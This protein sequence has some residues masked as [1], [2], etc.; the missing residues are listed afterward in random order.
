VTNDSRGRFDVVLLPLLALS[1]ASNVAVVGTFVANQKAQ[2]RPDVPIGTTLKPIAGTIDGGHATTVSYGGDKP[3]VLYIFSST[4]SWCERN[5][6]SISSLSEKAGSRYRF[7][8]IS[9]PSSGKGHSASFNF[10]VV[11][12]GGGVPFRATPQT[13]VVDA[14]GRVVKS[15][16]GAYTGNTKTE[17]EQFFSLKL[18][19]LE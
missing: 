10:P 5:L 18:P 14:G 3:V 12:T 6:A 11:L 16:M 9:L 8:G 19:N 7:I 15:W 2:G 17:I 1:L 13:L 4:C